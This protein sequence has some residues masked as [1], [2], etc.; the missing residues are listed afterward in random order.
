MKRGLITA[1][2]LCTAVPAPAQSPLIA[3]ARSYE[4]GTP[5]VPPPG[6]P[7][8]H[9]AAGLAKVVCSAVFVTGLAPEFAVENLGFFTA[10]YE[11]RAKLSRPVIDR[12][13][14]VVRGRSQIGRAH[15]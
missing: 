1:A 7:L 4:L 2:L 15:V 13:R 9:H 8:E 5:Y 14:K 11:A 3:R 10:P 12:A 6:D